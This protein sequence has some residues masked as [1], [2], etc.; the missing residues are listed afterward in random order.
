MKV[1][2][3][4]GAGFLGVH[5][6]RQLLSGGDRG[7]QLT[8]LDDL[9]RGKN[10]AELAALIADDRVRFVRADLT[11]PGAFVSLE[12]AYDEV[13]H[14]AAVLGVG[15]VLEH[16]Y[17]T[18]RVNTLSTIA[19][20]D[21]VRAGGARRLLFAST[22]EI[23]AWTPPVASIPV[24]TPESVPIAF[25]DLLNPRAT[26][27]LSKLVGEVA[28]A[29]ACA[30]G[31]PFVSVRY[32]NVY[33]P[34]MGTLHVIPQL[35]ERILGG[36]NPLKVYS[37]NYQRT[38]CYV[39]DAVRLTIDLMRC[40]QAE[41]RTVNVGSDVDE[42]TIGELAE[43][44]CAV[45]GVPLAIQNVAAPN[46]PIARRCPDMTEARRLTAFEP[47]VRLD[48]GLRRTCQWYSAYFQEAGLSPAG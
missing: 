17:E 38:F 3:T 16:P 18:L 6:A 33:G 48:Q 25:A 40:P 21:W 37:A 1:L 2:V 41:G 23:Y 19:L 28:V 29:H 30:S 27:A 36:E 14:L 13:Y 44:V 22:S 31:V 10:D 4:G 15:Y 42:F 35:I 24:P 8:L 45:I 26:Y 9:S 39:D 43:R 32:H 5:L 20:L 11:E 7:L 34:R 46:D 47:R 12:S